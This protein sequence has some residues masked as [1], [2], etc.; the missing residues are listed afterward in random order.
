MFDAYTSAAIA[1]TTAD[2]TDNVIT[3]IIRAINCWYNLIDENLDA[4][5]SQ[6]WIFSRLLDL[7]KM[8]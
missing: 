7:Y 1:A 4:E 5:E 8:V 2:P 6:M 3:P